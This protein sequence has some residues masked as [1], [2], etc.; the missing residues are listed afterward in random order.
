MHAPKFEEAYSLDKHSRD[1]DVKLKAEYRRERKGAIRELRKDS[2]FVAREKLKEDKKS[3]AEYHE[4]MRR[5]TAM[6]Q[7]EE[8]TA[9]N[10]YKR[11]KR[12][13]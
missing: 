7:T 5:L 3:S 4:K 9:A 1:A 13:K 11:A 12:S 6:V 8:G 10:E 2:K